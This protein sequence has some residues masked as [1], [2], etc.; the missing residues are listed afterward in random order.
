MNNIK[1][2]ISN[3][4]FMSIILIIIILFLVIIGILLRTFF[5]SGNE[6]G[7]RLK[8][9]EKVE[10]NK[11]DI[12][13]MEEELE[14]DEDVLEASINIKGRLI[15]IVLKIKERASAKDMKNFSK[16][17]LNSIYIMK[18]LKKMDIQQ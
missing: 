6:Y 11:K 8:G 10:I 13:K 5:P 9:I 14:S 3:N 16:D 7:D 2:F 17:K 4:K 1:K 15:N 18:I 12:E